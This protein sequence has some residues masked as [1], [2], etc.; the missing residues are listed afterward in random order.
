M[1]KRK[2]RPATTQGTR[3]IAV[4]K[5]DS[6]I[7]IRNLLL[8]TDI[9]FIL[10]LFPVT[11]GYSQT[12]LTLISNK[13]YAENE[14]IRLFSMQLIKIKIL[15]HPNLQTMIDEGDFSND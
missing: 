4:I 10:N 1:L 7:Y 3:F 13:H 9:C 15:A 8:V 14:R 11:T 6:D 5:A 2:L 12:S